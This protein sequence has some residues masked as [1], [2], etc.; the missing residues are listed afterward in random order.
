[1]SPSN[2][3]L[4][5]A[6]PKVLPP[7]QHILPHSVEAEQGVLGSILQS[8]LKAIPEC[9]EKINRDYFYV[10]AHKTT[11][12]ALLDMHDSGKASNQNALHDLTRKR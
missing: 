4:G 10:P 5:H 2:V 1:V 8:P 12:Q 9:V 11:Y 3:H 6:K 7:I